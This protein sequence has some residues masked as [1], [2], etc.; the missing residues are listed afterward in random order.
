M[1]SVSLVVIS[2]SKP[3][4]AVK[5]GGAITGCVA[6]DR[7]RDCEERCAERVLYVLLAKDLELKMT[8]SRVGPERILRKTQVM[9]TAEE[10]GVTRSRHGDVLAKELDVMG[11]RDSMQQQQS[12]CE[13]QLWCWSCWWWR[14]VE[15]RGV[16]KGSS[17]EDIP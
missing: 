16:T 12:L 9:Q 8:A 15:A 14:L 7:T 3:E 2:V 17:L 6:L 5:E 4:D 10:A 1:S 13:L 11:C